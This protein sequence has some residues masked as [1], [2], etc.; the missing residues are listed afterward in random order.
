MKR[1]THRT[2]LALTG[3]AFLSR[4]QAYG[5]L[6]QM[7]GMAISATSLAGSP[8]IQGAGDNYIAFE[9]ENYSCLN[10]AVGPVLWNEIADAKAADMS[11][12]QLTG[13]SGTPPTADNTACI[14]YQLTFYAPGNYSLYFRFFAGDASSDSFY[15][16][17][18]FNPDPQDETDFAYL[19]GGSDPSNY[20]WRKSGI[21]FSITDTDQPVTFMIKARENG[22]VLDRVV[23]ST[24]STLSD[25]ALNALANSILPAPSDV[26]HPRLLLTPER[27]AELAAWSAN[28]SRFIIAR[29]K[30][31]TWATLSGSGQLPPD[32]SYNESTLHQVAAQAMCYVLDNNQTA[33]QNAVNNMLAFYNDIDHTTTDT[34]ADGYAIYCSALV[35]DWCYPLLTTTEKQTLIANMKATAALM[36]IGYPPVNQS[37]VTGHA[38]EAQLF[39]DLLSAGVAVYDEDPEI[40]NYAAT[41]LFTKL[42][43]ARNFT[44]M[45]G[46]HH[47]GSAYGTYRYLWETFPAWLYRRLAGIEIFNPDQQFVPY[48]WIYTRYP[49]GGIFPECDTARAGIPFNCEDRLLLSAN[50]YRDPFVAE[51]SDR[52]DVEVFDNN[53]PVDFLLFFDPT[54][55]P[56]GSFTN[57]PPTRYFQEPHAALVARTDWDSTNAAIIKMNGAGHTFANHQHL[58]AGAFQIFYKGELAIDTGI[59]GSG[60]Y[61]TPYDWSINKRSIAH[62]T[63]LAYNPDE[64]FARGENDGG[65]M[66][67]NNAQEPA[68]LPTLLQHYRNGSVTAY[69]I[70]S[71]YSTMSV[72]LTKAYSE[73][74]SSYQRHF[75][76]LDLNSS[77]VPAALIV[78]DRMETADPDF[79]K[80]WLFQSL[81]QP[82]LSNNMFTVTDTR[83]NYNGKLVGTTL[84]PTNIITSMVGGEVSNHTVFGETYTSLTDND[85]S[86][87]WRLMRSPAT[88]QTQDHFLTVMQVMDAD[89]NQPLDVARLSATNLTGVAVDNWCVYFPTNTLSQTVSVTLPATQTQWNLL[90]TGL[91]A[92]DWNATDPASQTE[93]FSV[94]TNEGTLFLQG[95]PG[96]YNLTLQ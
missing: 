17:K 77:D 70:G 8:I 68:D 21:T 81:N 46:R 4:T 82:V 49:D 93:T 52:L 69:D 95:A 75:V 44:Y 73:K 9:A 30:I 2:I 25:S 37:S 24:V 33:G 19:G 26:S 29:Q 63:M 6:I 48:Y 80:Y 5:L 76:A 94:K 23:F 12:M 65:Q 55:E 60:S 10:S 3:L 16:A 41:R 91:D 92:G 47:Q 87:G 40:Y 15:Y 31:D 59:Y 22:L 72:D 85:Y 66:F 27:Q 51:L 89:Y 74:I 32:G 34:R 36:E 14:N 39:R 71:S 50:Y 79:K 28:D 61:G 38:G 90:L 43:P 54:I 67:K 78:Y 45:A 58:D 42:V 62:N 86:Q 20:Q 84:L 64:E 57:L 35:Y 53:K 1:H 7:L 56:A 11:A 83:G 88:A 13:Q 96:T 18:Q